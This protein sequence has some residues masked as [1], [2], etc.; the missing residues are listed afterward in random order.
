EQ[1]PALVFRELDLIR[2]KGKLQPVTL[3]EL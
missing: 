2:V 3:Y 1:D